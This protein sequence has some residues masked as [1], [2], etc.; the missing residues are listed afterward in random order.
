MGRNSRT[1]IITHG[2]CDDSYP[3]RTRFVF[4]AENYSRPAEPV[5]LV[6]LR[7]SLNFGEICRRLDGLADIGRDIRATGRHRQQNEDK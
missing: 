7:I 4:R 3:A 1:A 2:K 6:S 5:G